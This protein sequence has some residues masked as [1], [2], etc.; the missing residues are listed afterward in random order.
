MVHERLALGKVHEAP[1]PDAAY[2]GLPLI[3]AR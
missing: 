1:V 3:D 2:E